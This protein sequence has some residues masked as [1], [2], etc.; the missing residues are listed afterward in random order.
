MVDQPIKYSN[1]MLVDPRTSEET[2][3]TRA[4]FVRQTDELG[5][6]T[7]SYRHVRFPLTVTFIMISSWPAPAPPVQVARAHCF[8]NGK[9]LHP[10]KTRF[11]GRRAFTASASAQLR[12][13]LLCAWTN[14]T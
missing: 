9:G 1:V 13:V 3:S 14:E 8:C 2:R 4:M 11:Q 10:S 6:V 7:G 12:G 5:N